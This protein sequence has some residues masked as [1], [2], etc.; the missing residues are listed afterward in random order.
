MPQHLTV[1]LV[2]VVI[3][4]GLLSNLNIYRY[5]LEGRSNYALLYESAIAGGVL[6]VVVWYVLAYVKER[7]GFCT[8]EEIYVGHTCTFTEYL[9]Y[10]QGD[11]LAVSAILALIAVLILNYIFRWQEIVVKIARTSGLIPNLALDA[12]D[13]EWLVQVTTI[14]RK[15]YVGWIWRGLAITP[16]GEMP[17]LMLLPLR[18]GHRDPNTAQVNFDTHYAAALWKFIDELK[19]ENLSD[20]EVDERMV[21]MT[22]VIPV[23]EISLIRRHSEELEDEFVTD[24]KSQNTG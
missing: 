24:P 5:R 8:F 12:V 21:E 23:S 7:F 15:V 11:T 13:Q 16:K 18:S 3:G 4:Y 10:P 19:S 22:V 6:F 9:S 2:V 17:D 14:R 20:E 1:L